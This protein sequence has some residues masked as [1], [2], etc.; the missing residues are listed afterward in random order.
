VL[1]GRR[2][3]GLSANRPFKTRRKLPGLVVA[4]FGALAVAVIGV[5]VALAHCEGL[6]GRRQSPE[7]PAVAGRSFFE[8]L[9]RVHRA[10][11]GAPYTGLRSPLAAV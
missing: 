4:A 1:V 2:R 9:V 7:A 10:G 8:T 3:G 6:E 5:Q 11:E